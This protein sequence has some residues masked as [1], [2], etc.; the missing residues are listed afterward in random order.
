MIFNKG[1]DLS[2]NISQNHKKT[3]DAER[4]Y[5]PHAEAAKEERNPGKNTGKEGN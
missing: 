1:I 5:L 4:G 2:S 3:A